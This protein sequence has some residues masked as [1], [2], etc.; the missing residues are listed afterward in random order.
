MAANG[1]LPPASAEAREAEPR[2]A[3]RHRRRWAL[4][5]AAVLVVI[6]LAAG[7]LASWHY[8]SLVLAPDH[9]GWP[10][11]VEVEAV[12]PKRV[13]LERNEDTLRPGTYGLVWQAG[14][15]VVGRVLS[16][17]EDT[18]TRRLRDVDGYLG[19]GLEVGVETDVYT[20]NPSSRGLRYRTVPVRG[21][22]G[23]MPAWLVPGRSR[24]WA[25]VVHGINGTP[26]AGLR[27]APALHRTGLP[28]LMITYRDDIGAP[29]SPDGYHHMGETEWRDLQ[30]AS[31]YALAHG[32]RHLVLVG[33]SMGGA[34][35]ARF[36][37]QS[38]LAPR[39]VGA[40]PRRAGT[41]LEEDPRIQRDEDGLPVVLRS[42]GRVG[43]RRPHRRE[44]ERTRRTRPDRGL[45][46]P[47]PPLPRHRG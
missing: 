40:G 19:S 2:A 27:I 20:G 36:M 3:R 25:I 12:S 33:Y 24:T 35:V 32:A 7:V 14:H 47:D 31:R 17:D 5:A 16:S 43:D 41:E 34:L 23:R 29:E 11:N 18:V 1:T 6:V 44:L 37:E 13:V 21:E 9:S 4:I 10:E 15:A 39:V 30:A 26:E 45:P 46:P 38:P 28:T 42:P 8:A 22:L